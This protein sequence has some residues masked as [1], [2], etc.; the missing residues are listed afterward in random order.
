MKTEFI[1][2]NEERQVTLTA[3]LQETGGAFPYILKRP[4]I[5]ILPGGGYQYCS[6]REA[7]PVAM[8]YLKAGFQVFILRY[9]VNCHSAWPNPLNDYEQ[10][11]SLIRKNA[12]E[13]KVYEDKIA[14]LG[15][16]AGGHL[17]GC[18]ATMAKEKP[19]AALLGYAVTKASDVALCE[20][21]GPDVNA[22]VDEHT[23]PCFVFAACN[24]QI[25]PISNSLAFL[26]ALAQH[27]VTFESHIY[28]Y[29][30][31][32]FSTG[33]TSVQPAKTQMC[34]RIPSW[35]EDSIGWLRDVFG[36]FGET[37]MEEPECKSHVNGDFEPMLSGDCT[38]G[39]L[40]ICPEAGAVMKPIL[41]WIQEH[42]AEIMEHTG[43]ISAKTVQEQ[44]EECFYAIADDR[45]LKEILRYAKLPKEVENGI[46]DALSKIPNPRRKRKDK[47]GGAV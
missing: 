16:S 37:C 24:D 45:M 36:E 43:L 18:A 30:P 9:S 33:D 32:G 12:E 23:C 41:G 5:L 19:N 29:G 3:Y 1:T 13:W 14:V 15:F 17:A 39:Y 10:A 46:L 47:T 6:D 27:G 42:L 34:S 4:A 21:E 44:G 28:A 2:L 22:A 20:P 11:M 38:F 31:H 35:V 26:Q 8:P 40:R 7:D 25:V